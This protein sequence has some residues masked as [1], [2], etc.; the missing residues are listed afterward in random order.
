MRRRVR[1][2]LAGSNWAGDVWA[3]QPAN[4]WPHTRPERKCCFSE[5]IGWILRRVLHA[6]G[7]LL[8][9]YQFRTHVCHYK[10]S[11]VRATINAHYAQ[12]H[13]PYDNTQWRFRRHF[14]Q[15]WE[16]ATGTVELQVDGSHYMTMP[17]DSNGSFVGAAHIAAS[18]VHGLIF[19]YSGDANYSPVVQGT[20][21]TVTTSPLTLNCSPSTISNGGSTSCSAQVV[22]ETTGTI[23]VYLD[24]TLQGTSGV[25]QSG[26]V[27]ITIPSTALAPGTYSVTASYF[28]DDQTLS[29][30]ATQTIIVSGGSG[31]PGALYSYSI[32]DANNNSGYAANGNVMAY[33]DSVNGQWAL[34]YDS[35]NRL[36]SA[37]KAGNSYY[38]WAYDSFGN[39]TAQGIQSTPCPTTVFPIPSGWIQ[40]A[41]SA[42]N[43][44]IGTLDQSGNT[45]PLYNYDSPGNTG[46]MATAQGDNNIVNAVLYD[47]EGRVCA[48]QQPISPGLYSQTQYIYDAEGN[49]VAEGM[50]TD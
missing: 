32:T 10:S 45:V 28:L 26:S 11:R 8:G 35:L 22:G 27:N 47:G 18:G 5:S 6:S 42:G 37:G 4:Q 23:S 43:Q 17:L 15:Y 46:N 16:R 29:G 14:G 25:D 21:L 50:I 38:C 13:Q 48:T 33:T 36:T 44:L 20:Q 31:Q 12:L 40:M 41:I 30:T 9:R 34:G 19:T 7:I 1:H 49:R 3:S 24:G 2:P 39:R